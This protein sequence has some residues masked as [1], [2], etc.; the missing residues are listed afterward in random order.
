MSF[1]DKLKLAIE[2]SVKEFFKTL[3]KKYELDE[4]ELVSLWNGK[5]SSVVEKKK[6]PKK[7]ESPKLETQ[8]EDKKEPEIT[9]EKIMTATR[10][11]LAAMCKAKGLKMSGKK[12]ELVQRLLESL[13]NS[14]KKEVVKKT[15]PKSSKKEEPVVLKTV[16]EKSGHLEIRKNKFGNF[17]HVETG[18]VFNGD[19]MVYGRQMEDGGVS[20]L[21]PE[22]IEACKKYKFPY[23]LPENLSVNKSLDDVKV[24]DIDDE[25][26]LDEEDMEQEELEEELEEEIL[27]EE[28]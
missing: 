17:E 25:E 18:L 11:M 21:L 27:E 9:K 10:D 8:K 7:T 6:S 13:G 16:K 19:K 12:D 22:D 20:E 26:E 5:E 23:K 1:S 14:D 15:P 3:S 2:D 24:E 28:N 4:N